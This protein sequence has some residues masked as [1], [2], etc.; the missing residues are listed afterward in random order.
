[1]ETGGETKISCPD[2]SSAPRTPVWV[3]SGLQKQDSKFYYPAAV[4]A[5]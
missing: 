1:M 3:H 5:A 4:S 2:A